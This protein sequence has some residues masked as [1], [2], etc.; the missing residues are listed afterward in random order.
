[1]P[2]EM[3]PPPAALAVERVSDDELSITADVYARVV[4]VEAKN[5]VFSDNY[6]DLR[7]GETRRIAWRHA[8]PAVPV[9]EIGVWCWNGAPA[10]LT[11]KFDCF[12]REVPP[13]PLSNTSTMPSSWEAN[14]EISG[15]RV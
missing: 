15:R 10:G 13:M 8:D 6:F 5:A 1:M 11:A 14:T 7:P 2:Y 12:H 9:G 4:T 3:T